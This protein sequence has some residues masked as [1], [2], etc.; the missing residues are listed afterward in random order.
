MKW[1][2]SDVVEA[3]RDAYVPTYMLTNSEEWSLLTEVPL[4]CP[5][6]GPDGEP[7]TGYFGTNE[8]TIDVFLARAWSSGVG[9]R[10][11]AVEVKVT[12]ADYLQETDV[13]RA[14]AEVAAHQTTYAAPAGLIDPDTLPDGWGLME[15]YE[16]HADAAAGPGWIAGDSV[17]SRVK[18]RVKPRLREPS[19]DTDYL[20]AAVLRRAFRAEERIR[21]GADDAALVPQLRADAE[22]FEQQAQRAVSAR[23]RYRTQVTELRRMLHAVEGGQVCADCRE[24]VAYNAPRGVWRH[25]D[26]AQER[27]CREARA[28]ASRLRQEARTGARY[29]SGYPGPV[30]TLALRRQRADVDEDDEAV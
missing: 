9:H 7:R 1:T 22:R 21:R 11:I 29:L 16:T 20:V 15:V 27:T 28:E 6:V 17:R 5:K 24:P 25:K 3:I 10:R 26:K 19:C 23:D 2:A 4:R 18:W 30:E 12:R 13:K 8:R 14:P